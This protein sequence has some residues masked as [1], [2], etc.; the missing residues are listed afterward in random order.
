VYRKHEIELAD[1]INDLE[2]QRDVNDQSIRALQEQLVEA[3]RAID[4][5]G[6]G[7]SLGDTKAGGPIKPSFPVSARIVETGTDKATGAPMATINVGTNNQVR[8]NMQLFILRDGVYLADFIVTQ[9]DLQWC[10]G[11]ID[12]HGQ[13][14]DVRAGDK[15]SSLVTR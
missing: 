14:V 15:I 6:T 4:A 2:S 13:K 8:E 1:R 11:R 3:R 7:V 9:A 10:R 5:A 12:A